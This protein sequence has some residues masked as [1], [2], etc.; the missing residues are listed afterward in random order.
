MI[1]QVNNHIYGNNLVSERQSGFRKK[2]NTETALASI[3]NDIVRDLDR[4][5][6]V[7]VITI[8]FNKA[9]DC[10]LPSR[11]LDNMKMMG[12]SNIVTDWTYFLC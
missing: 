12:I 9:F 2:S 1:S 6:V 11:L 10:I 8:D 3:V 7:D 5:G 4:V